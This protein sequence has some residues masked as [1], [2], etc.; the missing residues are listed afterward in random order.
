[1]N[2]LAIRW[3]RLLLGVAIGALV[4]AGVVLL[5]GRAAGFGELAST[6]RR[7]D[8]GWFALCAVGQLAVFAGYAGVYRNAVAF[9]AGPRIRFWLSLRVVLAGFGAVQ[10]VAAAGAA[11]FAVH[12]WALRRLGFERRDAAVRL[13]G[14][15]TVVYLVFALGGWTAA[16]LALLAGSAPLGM[17]LPWLLAVPSLVAAAAWFTHP[18]RVGRWT[19][20]GGGWLREGL[21]IG[22][23]A[24]WWVRRS[25][26][27]HE[28]NGMLAWA[29]VYWLGGIL[30]LWGALRAFGVDLHAAAT[31]LAFATGYAAQI[32]P[33]PFTATGGVDAAMTFALT[34][35]GAPLAAA[36]LAV[37]AFRVFAFWIPLVPALVFLALLP[38]T[39]RELER[40]A[41]TAP[42]RASDV[43]I[44]T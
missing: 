32:V 9:G 42:P 39:G 1:M 16:L 25:L 3:G 7:G 21:A 30:S 29:A 27:T 18:S 26:G 4:A 24:A 11:A 13:I 20:P 2:E 5:I 35:V 37:V 41:R 19:A 17:T 12:Y 23:G 22:V 10:L 36:L 44:T 8:H 43:L 34:A 33:I 40:A 6:L 38:R 15:Q 28:G 31:V 14:F